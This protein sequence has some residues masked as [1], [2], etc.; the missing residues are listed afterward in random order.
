MR[1]DPKEIAKDLVREHGLDRARRI[2]PEGT[3][4]A[5]Y[6]QIERS[7]GKHCRYETNG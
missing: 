3:S 5:T 7:N 4:E 1:D 2:A 6:I